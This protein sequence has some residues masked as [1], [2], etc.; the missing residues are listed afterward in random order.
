MVHLK[1]QVYSTISRENWKNSM[2]SYANRER[3]W[4]AEPSNTPIEAA[5]KNTNRIFRYFTFDKYL[6][7]FEFP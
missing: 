5:S 7:G 6:R 1:P 4:E 2:L 3:A